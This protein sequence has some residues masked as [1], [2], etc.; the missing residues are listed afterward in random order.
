MVSLWS[1]VYVYQT[2]IGGYKLAATI[3]IGVRNLITF[4]VVG[5]KQKDYMVT[6]QLAGYWESRQETVGFRVVTLYDFAVSQ[7]RRQWASGWWPLWSQLAD[8]SASRQETV[9]FRVVTLMTPTGRLQCIKAGDSRLQNGNPLWP[10]LA[11]YRESRQEIVGFRMV[12]LM[13]TT[14]RLQRVKAG[15]D[16]RFQDGDPLWPQLAGYNASRQETIG[17]RMVILY[18]P[19]W[20]V[21]VHQSRR[22]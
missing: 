18:D 17:F 11:S 22:Q 4:H 20:Q 5:C 12:T 2:V 3:K 19:N 21:T 8:Y 14:G 15:G 13:T 1:P 9:G 10:Q 16:S 7:G 6:I